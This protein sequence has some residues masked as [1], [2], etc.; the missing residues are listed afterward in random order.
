MLILGAGAIIVSF[1]RSMPL[2]VVALLLNGAAWMVSVASYNIEIQLAAPRWVAGRTLAVFQAAIAGGIAI[3]GIV[4]GHVAQAHGVAAALL[5][6]G[7]AMLASPLLALWLKMPRTESAVE[8]AREA[9]ADPEM[10]LALTARSGP[11]VIEIEYYVDPGKAR[12]FYQASLDVQRA[13][14]RN[15]AYGWSIS[16][17]IADPELWTERFHCPTWHDYL[18]Q[19]SRA[20]QAERDLQQRMRDFH[21]GPQPV[22]IRRMLERPFGSVRWREDTPDLD[23]ET[24]PPLPTPGSL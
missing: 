3:G 17:D 14:Q 23:P 20:T 1:S 15:G 12:L 18:R 10:V 22:R 2:S 6:S 13:R 24:P 8:D 4:W 9:L 5:A 7:A 11:I 16:R 19:R 21:T